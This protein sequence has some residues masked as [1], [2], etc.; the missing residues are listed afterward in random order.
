[1]PTN[2]TITAIAMRTLEDAVAQ[3]QCGV[4]QRTW[5][6]RLA[7]SWLARCGVAADW[8]CSRFWATLEDQFEWAYTEQGGNELRIS[9]LMGLLDTWYLGLRQDRPSLQRR[10]RWARRYAPDIDM[11]SGTPQLPCMCNRYQPGERKRIEDH[12]SAKVLREYNE[13][14]ATVHPKEPGWVVRQQDSKMVLEQM[15]WGFPVVLR[16][17]KGQPLKPKPVNNARF[18]KLGAFWKR[19]ASQPEHRCL[20]P[21]TRYAEAVGTPGKM[22]E[23]WLSVRD[24]PVFA[25]AGL[26]RPSDEWGHSYTGVMTAN[27]LELEHIHDR[28]PV[29]LM[30]DQWHIWL[31]APLDELYQFDKPFPAGAMDV[32]VTADLWSKR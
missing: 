6:H 3:A 29:I 23:T 16:G 19:W 9:I 1:M 13:G 28:S 8:Q 30:P 26:W 32:Q 14:P 17:K 18:D 10:A 22:T 31:T 15:T 5:G 20:I 27:A 25:W 24:Q 21:A 11:D 7:L 2:D 4:A 12:F